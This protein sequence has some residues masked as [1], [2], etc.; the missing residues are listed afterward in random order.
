MIYLV[1]GNIFRETIGR[2]IF[3]VTEKVLD[4]WYTHEQNFITEQIKTEFE[5]KLGTEQT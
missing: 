5:T 2:Y 4:V 1:I 3:A